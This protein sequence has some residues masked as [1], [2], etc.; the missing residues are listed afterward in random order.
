MRNLFQIM[1][2]LVV[3]L[4][5]VGTTFLILDIVSLGEFRETIQKALLVLAVFAVAGIA[6]SFLIRPKQS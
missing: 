6:M 4:L 1:L 2:I 5:A 3:L